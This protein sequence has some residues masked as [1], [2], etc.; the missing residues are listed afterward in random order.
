MSS[1]YTLFC[2]VVPERNYPSSA[3]YFSDLTEDL[4][5]I[6]SVYT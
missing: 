3:C 2:K 4:A 1:G 6:L 5:A